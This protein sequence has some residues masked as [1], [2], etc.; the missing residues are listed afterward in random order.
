LANFL[1][2]ILLFSCHH[3]M[4]F[5]KR[6]KIMETIWHFLFFIGKSYKNIWCWQRLEDTQGHS[7]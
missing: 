6:K 5:I 7:C 4:H 1:Q 3:F 2:F